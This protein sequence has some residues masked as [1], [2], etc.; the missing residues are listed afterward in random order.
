[1]LMALIKK[2]KSKGGKEKVPHFGT[3]ILVVPQ[4]LKSFVGNQR[5]RSFNR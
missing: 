4:D 5:G 1:M 2:G 3:W